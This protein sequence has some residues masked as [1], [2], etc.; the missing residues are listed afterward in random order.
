[1]EFAAAWVPIA[2][3]AI[4]ETARKQNAS[5]VFAVESHVIRLLLTQ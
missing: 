4:I 3:L 1:M 5:I 2:K